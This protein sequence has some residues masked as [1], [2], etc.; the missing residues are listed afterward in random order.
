MR[1][2]AHGVTS[3]VAKNRC[4]AG[5]TGR[6]EECIKINGSHTVVELMRGGA[7]PREACLEALRRVAANYGNDRQKLEQFG[8][9]FYAVNKRGEH[10]AASLWN[11]NAARTRRAQYAVNDGGASRLVDCAY[12]FER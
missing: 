6:G 9:D 7:T 2:T 8:L 5:S 4:G 12:L 3:A 11:T 1:D 10:A